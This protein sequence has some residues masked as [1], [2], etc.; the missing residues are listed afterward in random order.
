METTP[1]LSGLIQTVLCDP[2]YKELFA[3]VQCERPDLQIVAIAPSYTFC[4]YQ[5]GF[6]SA[7]FITTLEVVVAAIRL[8]LSWLHH[9]VSSLP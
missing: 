8:L 4:R 6:I 5:E 2:L 1:S 3:H 9:L 7:V